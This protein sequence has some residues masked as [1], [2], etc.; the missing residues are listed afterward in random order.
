MKLNDVAV[1]LTQTTSK[2][3]NYCKEES[4]SWTYNLAVVFKL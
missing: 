4:H 2:F 1:L 3:F